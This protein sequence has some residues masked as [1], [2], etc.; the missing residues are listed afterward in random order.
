MRWWITDFAPNAQFVAIAYHSKVTQRGAVEDTLTTF[1]S[2]CCQSHSSLCA[3]DSVTDWSQ[4]REK[5]RHLQNRK[6]IT[7]CTVVGGRPRH[8]HRQHKHRTFGEVLITFS[9]TPLP[10]STLHSFRWLHSAD[11]SWI[12]W[13][14]SLVTLARP[15]TLS[16]LRI[17]DHSFQYASHRLWNQL[18]A[19]LRQPLTNLS[20]SDSPIR[21]FL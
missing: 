20:N 1:L 3:T 19:S 11:G 2:P 4:L 8:R 16:S 5:W 21:F 13:T 7:C 9:P 18:P 17:T 12:L 14:S 10:P 15:S 6:Y